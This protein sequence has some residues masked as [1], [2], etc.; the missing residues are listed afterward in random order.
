M[1]LLHA[2]VLTLLALG[3]IA[4]G[5]SP[6]AEAER[7]WQAADIGDY[8]IQVREVHS[9][10]CLY[11]AEVEVRG[12]RVVSATVTARPG[13]AQ[14]CYLY[15]DGI[16]GKP[17]T[18]PPEEARRWTVEGLFAT[19]H[20]LEAQR[21]NK[22]MAVTLTFDPALGYPLTLAGDNVRA[23]DDD[24]VITVRHFEALEE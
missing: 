22:E 9:I 1:K 14:D 12:G 18:I 19:A 10:W 20:A 8:R 17:V 7:R 4:C 16:V 2:A 15:V 13:P 3:L 6:V 21:G 24:L 11:D 23:T 5:A